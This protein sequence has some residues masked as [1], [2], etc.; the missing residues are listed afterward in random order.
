MS[1]LNFWWSNCENWKKQEHNNNL[2]HNVG[3]YNQII[4]EDI[5]LENESSD[6][7]EASLHESSN[8]NTNYFETI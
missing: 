5:E 4:N 6:D 1:H 2:Q 8:E 3:C 7:T